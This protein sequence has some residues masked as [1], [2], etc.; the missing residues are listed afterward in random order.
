MASA[1]PGEHAQA[2]FIRTHPCDD[3]FCLPPTIELIKLSKEV[4]P[5]VVFDPAGHRS[6][7]VIAVEADKQLDIRHPR[8]AAELAA[9]RPSRESQDAPNHRPE[10][11]RSASGLAC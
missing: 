1:V 11:C 10:S 9:R 5:H 8:N 2:E 7:K 4:V 6:G 3:C